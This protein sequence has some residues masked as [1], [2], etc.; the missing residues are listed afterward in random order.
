MLIGATG[1]V[2]AFISQK[3]N[4]NQ[5]STIQLLKAGNFIV[6][7]FLFKPSMYIW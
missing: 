7:R 1:K 4:Y 6:T 2:D 3:L 5:S